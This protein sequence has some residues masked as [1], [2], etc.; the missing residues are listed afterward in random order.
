MRQLATLCTLLTISLLPVWAQQD[1]ITT[2]IGGGPND[3]PAVQSDVNGPYGVAFDSSGNYYITASNRV[4]KVDTT[5]ILTVVA[6]T[7]VA[8]YGGDGVPGGAANA[9]L[10]LPV[11]IAV[12]SAGNIYVAEYNNCVIREIDTTNTVT[13]I[14]GV[15]GQ[16]NYNGDGAPATSYHLYHPYGLALDSS[17]DLYFCDQANHRVRKL[18]LST[19][20]IDTY[21]GTGSAGYNG[22]NIPATTA[23]LYYPSGIAVDGAGDIFIADQ[24]N[25]R[26]REVASSTAIIT[27]VAGNG[28]DGFAGDTGLATLAKI[29]QVYNGIAVNTAGTTVTI[30]DAGNNERIRQFTVGGDIATI[31]GTGSASFCGDG[32]LAT[33]ACLNK[34]EGIAVTSSGVVYFADN[35]NNRVR[36]FTIGG[37]ISTVAGNGSTT[38]PTLVSGAPP[39]GVVFNSVGD[40]MEDPSGNVF[41]SDQNNCMVRELV[42]STGL[43]NIFAGS[44]AAGATTGT[45]GFSGEGGPA[46]SAE[47]GTLGGI[48]RDSSG[49]I[50][51]ADETNCVVWEVNANTL[52]ISIFAGVTPKS[53]GFSGDG[54]PA[55]GAKLNAPNG[56]FVDSKDNVYIGDSSN[57]RVREITGGIINTIAGNGSAGYL[58]DGDPATVAELH[59][60]TGVS[61]DSAGNVYIADYDNCVIREVTAAT[62]IISTLAGNGVCG[63][64]GDGSATEHELNHPNRV[65]LDANGNLFISDSSSQRVRWVTP[66]GTM[67]TIAGDGTAGLSGDGG[68][69]LSAKLNGPN[70]VTQ[71]ASGNFLLADQDNNRIREVTAFSALNTSDSSLDFGL[72]T[73]GTTS[74]PQFLTLSALGPLT[75]SNI[76][77]SSGPFT[78]WD[79]CG[80]G[81]ANAATCFMYVFFK[82]TAAGDATGTITIEDNGF[83]SNTTTI[84]LEGTGGAI[85][86]TGGPL[87]FGNQ[88]VGTTSAAKSVTVANKGKTSVTMKAITLNE[89]DFAISANTCPAAGHALA[90]GKSCTVSVAFAPKTT[91]A[92]KGALVVNDSDPSS[93]QIVG[94]TGTGTSMVAFNPSSLVFPDQAVGTTSALKKVTLTNKTGAKLTLKNP[95]LSVTG[96]FSTTSASTCTKNLAIAAGGTC[97]IYVE[98][99]PTSAGYPTGTL[100]VFDSDAT[101]PQVVGLSGTG[102]GVEFT[103]STVSLSSTVGKQ[104]SISVNITN[105]GTS[106]ITFTAG[107]ISGPNASDW[108]TNASNPPCGGSLAPGAPCTFTVYFKPSIVGSESATYLVYDSS[109]GSPQSLP[110]SGTGQ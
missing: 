81:L 19:D 52:D 21:A 103:P 73:V 63:F 12:D 58:G 92:K 100:S 93:P 82:P 76:S 10:N 28:T 29:S 79:D 26:I 1:V 43:V 85:S 13:T 89:T 60:P 27:T 77:I 5:G 101:S 69:A 42:N 14:A 88:G 45:C 35:G 105:V 94:L 32:G 71:D 53:C 15:A 44:A 46:T 25:Y 6:G 90:G 59:D 87:L 91:G 106:T 30:G 8:G 66:A 57:N 31:A 33:S 86:V 20:T 18:V 50:Y 3:I 74:D 55:A 67:T 40:V 23:K 4:Y 2:A 47:L 72:V 68:P 56:V 99:T 97:V 16:C 7:G 11:G 96:P 24:D 83:F 110:L 80:T 107:G 78:E 54:G 98:F 109:S 41:I 38:F 61:V 104:V 39:Q 84:T 37:D 51:I 75:F 64:N 102:T 49:N 22:D 17:G 65:H 95:P 36:Q 108:S 62:G 70:G 34:P 48:A 9:V